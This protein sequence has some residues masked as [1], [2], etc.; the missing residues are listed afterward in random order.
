MLYSGVQGYPQGA[1]PQ[2]YPSAYGASPP[3]GNAPPP[4]YGN[5]PPPNYGNVPP[6]NYGNVPPPNYGNVPPS[7]YGNA[8]P[9][10]YG[11]PTLPY[12]G[13]GIPNIMQTQSVYQPGPAVYNN[14][15]A[16]KAPSTYLMT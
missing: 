15:N 10:T 7:N 9:P 12:P 3:Y 11:N 2:G 4:A 14:N 16:V 1:P 13:T 8:P 5:V 6:P